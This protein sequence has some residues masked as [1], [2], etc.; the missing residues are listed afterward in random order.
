[1][2]KMTQLKQGRLVKRDETNVDANDKVAMLE[3]QIAHLKR[4]PFQTSVLSG[5]VAQL[6]A[7]LSAALVERARVLAFVEAGKTSSTSN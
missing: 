4:A 1:M 2:R 7:E 6:E 3:S 5:M